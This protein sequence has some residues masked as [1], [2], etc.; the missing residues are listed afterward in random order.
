MILCYSKHCFNISIYLA[1]NEIKG[2]T[3]G[4]IYAAYLN[5]WRIWGKPQKASVIRGGNLW[6]LLSTFCQSEDI[7]NLNAF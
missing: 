3:L 4:L 6:Y 2:E 1:S 5:A 7:Q